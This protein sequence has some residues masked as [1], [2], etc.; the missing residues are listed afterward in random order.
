[1]PGQ[2]TL[3]L[4]DA[5]GGDVQEELQQQRCLWIQGNISRPAVC[6]RLY[7]GVN[8]LNN[9]RVVRIEL[10]SG[11]EQEICPARPFVWGLSPD[12]TQVACGGF[13][14]GI[15]VYPASGGPGRD[16]VKGASFGSIEWT[17][18]GKHI[19]YSVGP[20]GPAPGY[21]IV[22]A[23]GGQPR[24]LQ[25]DLQATGLMSLSPDGRKI[26]ITTTGSSIELW[27]LENV[28]SQLK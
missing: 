10:G 9:T 19:L 6:F 21:W 7:R 24:K 13:G 18:D 14:D 22:P 3:V 2:S 1:M 8:E 27:A 16:L 11:K 17:P 26:A 15:R 25:I 28:F 23:Q 5:Q 4:T 12:A 20:T